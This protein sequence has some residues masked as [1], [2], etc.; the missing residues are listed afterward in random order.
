MAVRERG[1]DDL[2]E[3]GGERNVRTV[4]ALFP[5]RAL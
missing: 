2:S 3:T 4:T 1:R 5:P